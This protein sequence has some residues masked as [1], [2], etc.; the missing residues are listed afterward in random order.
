M[1]ESNSIFESYIP[2]LLDDEV[3][4][5]T[6]VGEAGGEDEK[7]MTA[8]LNVLKN[9]AKKKKTSKVGEALRPYRF[10]MW[11]EVTKNVSDRKDYKASEIKKIVDQFKKHE[12][13]KKALDLVKS[14]PADI[15]KGANSYYAYKGPNKISPPD[16]TKKWKKTIDIGNH[17]FG[18]IEKL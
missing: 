17:R 13:W 14:K 10:S 6:L 18:Y 1:F 5:A 4:A 15:T 3:I 12:K 11:N 8:V 7:G 9:R 16:F 2:T